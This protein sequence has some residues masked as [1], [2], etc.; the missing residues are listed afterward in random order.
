MF[1]LTLLMNFAADGGYIYCNDN[2]GVQEIAVVR[3]LFLGVMGHDLVKGGCFFF[4]L[5]DESGGAG[6][7]DTLIAHSVAAGIVAVGEQFMGSIHLKGN[8]VVLA[9]QVQ[10]VAFSGAMEK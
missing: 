6:T 9:N 10:F 1:W 2:S 3:E 7:H 5:C 4:I 8:L